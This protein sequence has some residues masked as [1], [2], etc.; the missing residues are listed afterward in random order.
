MKP[1]VYSLEG[2]H[3]VA[4]LSG[5]NVDTAFIGCDAFD[6]ERGAMTNSMTKIDHETG[7]DEKRQA[8][9]AASRFQQI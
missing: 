9:G 7:D 6:L 8:K 3:G 2:H 4:M 1:K 5:F